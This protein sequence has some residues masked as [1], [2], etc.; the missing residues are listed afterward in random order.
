LERLGAG[1]AAEIVRRQLRTAGVRG[2]A[3]GPRP[4]TRGNPLGLTDRQIEI[5]LLLAEGLRNNE[6]AERLSIAPKTVDHHVSAVLVKLDVGSRAQAIAQAHQLGLV[7]KM[8]K[9]SSG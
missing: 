4:A 6:I 3:R 9:S 7:P 1:P 5:L 2:L 8:G